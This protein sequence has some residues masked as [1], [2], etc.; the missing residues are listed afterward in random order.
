LKSLSLPGLDFVNDKMKSHHSYFNQSTLLWNNQQEV[1]Y[2]ND[3]PSTWSWKV[4]GLGNTEKA[5]HLLF[6]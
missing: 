1:F 4:M 5:T 6:Q 2:Q 3:I